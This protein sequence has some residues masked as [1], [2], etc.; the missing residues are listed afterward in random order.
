M[1]IAFLRTAPRNVFAIP[2]FAGWMSGRGFGWALLIAGIA[3]AAALL[4]TWLRWRRFT[5]AVGTDELLIQQGVL[6]LSRR[7]TKF[8]SSMSMKFRRTP[9]L[10]LRLDFLQF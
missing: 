3:A 6:S 2:V 5:Y 1:A 9:R 10:H 4:F 8:T 7:P